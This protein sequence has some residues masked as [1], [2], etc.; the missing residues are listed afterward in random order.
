[1]M[2][3][4]SGWSSLL[5]MEV[6]RRLVLWLAPFMAAALAWVVYEASPVEI[7]FWPDTVASIQYSLILYGPLVGGISV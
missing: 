4:S 5:R 3:R 7:W 1:M 6:R 2:G